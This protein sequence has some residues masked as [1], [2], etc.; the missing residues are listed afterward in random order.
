[1]EKE[2]KLKEERKA[3]LDAIEFVWKVGTMGERS[4]QDN[5]ERLKAFKEKWGDCL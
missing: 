2:G 1:M 4:W 5:F 3:E